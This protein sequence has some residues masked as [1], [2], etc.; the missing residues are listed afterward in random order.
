MSLADIKRTYYANCPKDEVAIGTQKFFMTQPPVDIALSIA[1][2][3]PKDE[4]EAD[5]LGISEIQE[6][7][8]LCYPAWRK[9][10][11]TETGDAP[12]DSDEG[13]EFLMGLPVTTMSDLVTS[14]LNVMSEAARPAGN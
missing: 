8:Q 13:Q 9:C 14:M 10:I 2:K 1:D 6:L 4:G 5:D 11:V 12:F 7:A 3:L